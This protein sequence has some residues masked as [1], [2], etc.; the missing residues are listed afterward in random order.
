MLEYKIGF[1]G[2][3]FIGKNMADDFVERGYEVVRF[4]LE[5][6][7]IGN[8]EVIADCDFVFIAVPTPTTP[9]GFD[10]SVVESVLPLIGK[11]RQR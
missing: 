1:I 3:G 9:Q 5:E 2:Q 6:K 4:A 8:R 10:I 11:G 7:Y